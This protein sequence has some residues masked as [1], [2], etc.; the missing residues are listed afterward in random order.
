M[1]AQEPLSLTSCWDPHWTITRTRNKV[2]WMTHQQSGKKKVLNI[3]KVRLVDPNIVWD[4]VNPRPIRNPRKTTKLIGLQNPPIHGGDIPPQPTDA[5]RP[6]PHPTDHAPPPTHVKVATPRN[7]PITTPPHKNTPQ[8]PAKSLKRKRASD[9]PHCS[10]PM[11]TAPSAKPT[12]AAVDTP[13]PRNSATLP[14]PQLAP[15]QSTA[16]QSTQR[17]NFVQLP[18]VEHRK[19]HRSTPY[20]Q[21]PLTAEPSQPRPVSVPAPAPAAT[22]AARTPATSRPGPPNKADPKRLHRQAPR[23][24]H[25]P[26]IE[27]SVKRARKYLPRG[28]KRM[29]TAPSL[30]VQKKARVA[31]INLVEQ[32]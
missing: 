26:D 11:V 12:P 10:E 2:L 8:Q 15:I 19:S 18:S 30:A 27:L 17:T 14:A 5:N 28:A 1:K 22:P 21:K 4:T 13:T 31:V 29:C 9:T 16:H 23:R 7:T 20:D 25:A 3:N 6:A 32:L 24:T